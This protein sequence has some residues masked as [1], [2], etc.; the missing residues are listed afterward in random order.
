MT[1]KSVR[2]SMTDGSWWDSMRA[3]TLQDQTML[4]KLAVKAV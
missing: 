2:D 4:H 3:L 1:G